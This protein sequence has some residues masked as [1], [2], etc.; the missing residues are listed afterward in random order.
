MLVHGKKLKGFQ[1]TKADAGYIFEGGHDGLSSRRLCQ[2]TAL[3]S[4]AGPFRIYSTG[5][6]P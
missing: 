6:A 4:R 2:E 1:S 5:A 3:R